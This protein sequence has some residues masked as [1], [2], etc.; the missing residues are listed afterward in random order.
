MYSYFVTLPTKIYVIRIH[1]IHSYLLSDVNTLKILNLTNVC[2]IVQDND[3]LYCY[4]LW[5][6]MY[7][8]I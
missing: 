6:F 5:K 7:V 4:I 8:C 1:N 3:I 2:Q